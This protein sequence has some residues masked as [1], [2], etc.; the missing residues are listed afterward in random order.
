LVLIGI[1]IVH[2]FLSVRFGRRRYTSVAAVENLGSV[3][4]SRF[5]FV[6]LDSFAG[7][8]WKVLADL[9][10]PRDSEPRQVFRQPHVEVGEVE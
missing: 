2:R 1:L 3:Q 10:I 7:C 4:R 9:D 8:F 6:L 5:K